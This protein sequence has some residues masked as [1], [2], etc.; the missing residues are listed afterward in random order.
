MIRAFSAWPLVWI[1]SICC[2]IAF[3][4][5]S[6]DVYFAEPILLSQRRS[7]YVSFAVWNQTNCLLPDLG[8]VAYF[9]SLLSRHGIRL[10][11]PSQVGPQNGHCLKLVPDPSSRKKAGVSGKWIY[12]APPQ[13][14]GGPFCER[15]EA[16]L[17]GFSLSVVIC[18][19]STPVAFKVSV[20]PKLI[21]RYCL[22]LNHLYNTFHGHNKMSK[23]P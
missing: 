12:P 23:F 4:K 18:K 14:C 16:T 21:I 2:W 6:W 19:V 1:C 11:S 15:R 13:L 9:C 7:I 20:T 10:P 8:E 3:W 17:L 22:I 5:I